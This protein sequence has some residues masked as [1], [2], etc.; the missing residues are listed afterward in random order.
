MSEDVKLDL[1][2]Q[3][4]L[5]KHRAAEKAAYEYFCACE[6]GDERS[7]AFEVYENIRNA[8]RVA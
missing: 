5:E 8:T 6:V 1:L 4:L 3:D 7:R 2:K